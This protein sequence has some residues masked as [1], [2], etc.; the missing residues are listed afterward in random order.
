MLQKIVALRRMSIVVMN[1]PLLP[2]EAREML[3]LIVD[4]LSD[5]VHAEEKRTPVINDTRP[6]N[7]N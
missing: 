4:I 6:A 2:R 7:Q 3:A 5:L 1:H